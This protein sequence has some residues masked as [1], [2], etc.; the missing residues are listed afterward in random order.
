M[1]TAMTQNNALRRVAL[2]LYGLNADD[3]NWLLHKLPAQYQMPLRHLIGDLKQLGFSG[4][5]AQ[6]YL[7]KEKTQLPAQGV[8]KEIESIE[9]IHTRELGLAAD[10]LE[11]INSIETKRMQAILEEQDPY[12]CAII[13]HA[14]PWVWAK[15]VWQDLPTSL[16]TQIR[17]LMNEV[18]LTHPNFMRAVLGALAAIK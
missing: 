2:K 4:E 6:E 8:E 14:H 7:A 11:S 16:Q 12:L 1:N 9:G 15:S 10:T 17:A 3:Q 13:F 18:S 5:F